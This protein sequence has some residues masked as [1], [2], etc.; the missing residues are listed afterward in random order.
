MSHSLCLQVNT[1]HVFR[2][3]ATRY[4]MALWG[5]RANQRRTRQKPSAPWHPWVLM[6]ISQ[7]LF[8]TTRKPAGQQGAMVTSWQLHTNTYCF[9]YSDE[10]SCF[11][12]LPTGPQRSQWKRSPYCRRSSNKK[13]TRTSHSP[14]SGTSSSSSF[15]SSSAECVSAHTRTYTGWRTSTG[16][17]ERYRGRSRRGLWQHLF[18]YWFIG[19]K[20]EQTTC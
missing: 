16:W 18:F 11:I 15:S 5:L 17:G 13:H 19:L 8:L 7:A 10:R 1:G 9:F 20:E 14:P 12:L 6:L 2:R 3:V 4:W